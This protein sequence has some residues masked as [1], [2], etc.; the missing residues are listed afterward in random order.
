MALEGDLLLF[1]QGV[2]ANRKIARFFVYIVLVVVG[3]FFGEAL[4]DAVELGRFDFEADQAA[5]TL[6]FT[7]AGVAGLVGVLI[8]FRMRAKGLVL[9]DNPEE[10]VSYRIIYMG[11]VGRPGALWVRDKSGK[12]YELPLVLPTLEHNIRAIE[13][14]EKHAPH[15]EAET[16]VVRV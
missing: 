14:F 1:E 7:G 12:N 6:V 13:A 8:K 10:I 3:V 9:L 11:E 2:N 4:Y 5:R 15:A 16:H